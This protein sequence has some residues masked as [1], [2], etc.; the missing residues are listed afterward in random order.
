MIWRCGGS[1]VVVFAED[2]KMVETS[3]VVRLNHLLSISL[4]MA[5]HLDFR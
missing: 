1:E 5:G 3:P 2:R 4:L